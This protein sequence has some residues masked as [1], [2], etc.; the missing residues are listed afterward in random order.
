MFRLVFL[1][2]LSSLALAYINKTQDDISPQGDARMGADAV[3]S[4]TD[5]DDKEL[6][7]QE[8]QREKPDTN[9]ESEKAKPKTK[10][11]QETNYGLP[12]N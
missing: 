12:P 7:A 4:G 8:D 9:Q 11:D 6:Q 2:L 5:L 10:S 3:T 1:L